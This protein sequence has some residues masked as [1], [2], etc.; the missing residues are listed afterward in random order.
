MLP[1]RNNGNK[2]NLFRKIALF[3]ALVVAFNAGFFSIAEANPVTQYTKSENTP[4]SEV[5]IVYKEDQSLYSLLNTNKVKESKAKHGLKEKRKT[6]NRALYSFNEDEDIN[7]VIALLEKDINVDFVQPNF[8]YKL[9]SATPTDPLY[10]Q[11][12]GNQNVKAVESW[13]IESGKSND[14][15]VAVIDDGLWFNHPDIVNGLWDGSLCVDSSG[16]FLGKCKGGYDFVYNDK[17]P[18]PTSNTDSHGTHV[19]GIIAATKNNSIGVSGA[20][21]NTKIMAL[22]IADGDNWADSYGISDAVEFAGQNGAKVINASWGGGASSCVGAHDPLLYS[23]IQGFD[24]IFAAAAGNSSKNHD[25]VSYFDVP[26]GYSSTTSCWQGLD[27]VISVAASNES[28]NLATFPVG[29]SDYGVAVDIAA[30]GD[31]IYSTVKKVTPFT[32]NY[33]YSENFNS[34]SNTS[35]P[36]GWTK[37]GYFGVIQTG[38]PAGGVLFGDYNYPSYNNNASY[39]VTSPSINLAN[40]NL[41]TMSFFTGCDTPN[42]YYDWEDYM[43]LYLFN[44]ISWQEADLGYGNGGKYDQTELVRITGQTYDYSNGNFHTFSL[45]LGN[46]FYKSNFKFKFV[47]RTDDYLSYWDGC[48]I[49]NILINYSKSGETVSYGYEK[50]PGTS[51]AAPFVAGLASLV[52]SANPSL[53]PSQVK[54]YIMENGDVVGGLSLISSSKKINYHKTLEAV[55]GD[56]RIE[57]N[58]EDVIYLK[59]GQS[60]TDAGARW[61]DSINGN[62][63]L[64]R[65]NNVNQ[66]SYGPQKINYTYDNT[67]D[68][69]IN[70]SRVVVVYPFDIVNNMFYS[71]ILNLVKNNAIGGY[72]GGY[73]YPNNRVKRSEVAA[74]LVRAL[75]KSNEAITTTDE[76]NYGFADVPKSHWAYKSIILARK[77]GIVGGRT[78]SSFGP[79]YSVT[80]AELSA[81]ISRVIGTYPGNLSQLPFTD[82]K[83]HWA[84]SGIRQMYN[85]EIVN[86]VS[87]TLFNPN[88]YATRGQVAKML[89]VPM[90]LKIFK[91]F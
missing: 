20:S 64:A 2:Y 66:W 40:S 34:T 87:A 84:E 90:T 67:R 26:S 45:N 54:S 16:A 77:Y 75:G 52:Y 6:K 43:T 79:E 60:Y 33:V 55:V 32:N 37:V 58:G 62:G 4:K 89:N 9:R 74:I 10:S 21:P 59:Y 53:T 44:G 78:S 13:A 27:N 18:T 76:S 24:G 31:D 41:A 61:F 35:I 14:S 69:T 36:N 85:Y 7:E 91:I 63:N 73:F 81:M 88:G 48:G 83:N 22:K 71:H 72:P 1:P 68:T 23:A 15:I 70:R 28:N 47:C 29:G 30:P 25:N 42:S 49:D 82:T 38:P 57:L 56:P 39:S 46:S 17:D 8:Y 5:V 51:M 12:W 3:S 86:G 11:Q 65:T 50:W 80:R 19:A